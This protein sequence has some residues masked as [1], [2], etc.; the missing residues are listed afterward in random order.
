MCQIYSYKYGKGYD[1]LL[2]KKK[3]KAQNPFSSL[4]KC[5]IIF[6]VKKSP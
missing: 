6:Y 2:S 1:A 5:I 4:I 3:I